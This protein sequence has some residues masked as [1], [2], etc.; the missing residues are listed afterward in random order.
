M[1]DNKDVSYLVFE[2]TMARF[3][4]TVS[5]L[6]VAL[7][8]TIFLLVATNIAWISYEQQFEDVSITQDSTNGYNS[9]IGNDGDIIN[10]TA[11]N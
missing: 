2:S 9:Y 1:S 11:N 3:E 5:R 10:G 7:I 4:R 6:W 8:I